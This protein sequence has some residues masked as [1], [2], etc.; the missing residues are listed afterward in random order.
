MI[1]A[2]IFDM[3]GLMI[4]SEELHFKAYKKVLE[5]FGIPF[6][7]DDYWKVWGKD[8]EMCQRL[9]EKHHVSIT[10]KELLAKKNK[11][12]RNTFN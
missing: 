12:F 5:K 4:D 1:Q 9:T 2:I 3:D 6:T 8:S 10:T 11:V 7:H